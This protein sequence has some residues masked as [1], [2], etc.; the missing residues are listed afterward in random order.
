MDRARNPVVFRTLELL[1][2]DLS[3]R[4][5]LDRVRDQTIRSVA[6]AAVGEVRPEFELN[7]L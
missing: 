7:F 6:G 4:G 5:D 3:T 2:L 1:G